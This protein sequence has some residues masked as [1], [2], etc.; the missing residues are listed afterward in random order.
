MSNVEGKVW[1][2]HRRGWP[3]L[4]EEQLGWLSPQCPPH[5]APD[6]QA[7]TLLGWARGLFEEVL[8]LGGT[9][10]NRNEA[11]PTWDS[12]KVYRCCLGGCSPET[13]ALA[14]TCPLLWLLLLQNIFFVFLWVFLVKKEIWENI[15]KEKHAPIQLRNGY[16]SLC[17]N[18]PPSRPLPSLVEDTLVLTALWL[19]SVISLRL[20]WFC[21]LWILCKWNHAMFILWLALSLFL[22]FV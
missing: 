13:W 3:S 7:A 1:G 21:M 2:W 16:H 20:Y 17:S 10:G 11:G 15:Y 5:P 8:G 14:T 18:P 6:S 9:G 12:V 19:C 4:C 22:R